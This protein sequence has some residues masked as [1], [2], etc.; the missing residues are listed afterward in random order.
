MGVVTMGDPLTMA[1]TEVRRAER[2]EGRGGAT[3][4]HPLCPR[5]APRGRNPCTRGAAPVPGG[6]EIAAIDPASK[7]GVESPFPRALRRKGMEAAGPSSDG[8]ERGEGG[9][10]RG[11]PPRRA[12]GPWRTPPPASRNL[13]GGVARDPLGH[14]V[15]G[16]RDVAWDPGPSNRQG[17]NGPLSFLGRQKGWSQIGKIPNFGGHRFRF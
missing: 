12:G 13:G 6:E 4:R 14:E 15:Q 10:G 2:G 3:H 11:G 9:P 8:M 16:C 1:G 7:R 17:T 5:A